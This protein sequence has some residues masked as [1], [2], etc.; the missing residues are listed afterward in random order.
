M[1][2]FHNSKIKL[3]SLQLLTWKG[4]QEYC[5]LLRMVTQYVHTYIAQIAFDNE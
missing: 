2:K 4:Q 3:N 1:D 5:K